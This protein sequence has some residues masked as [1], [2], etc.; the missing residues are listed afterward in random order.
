MNEGSDIFASSPMLVITH[1]FDYSL[2]TE[3][4]VMILNSPPK[5]PSTGEAGV[6]LFLSFIT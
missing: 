1:L 4:S 3:W 6:G 2:L 5:W